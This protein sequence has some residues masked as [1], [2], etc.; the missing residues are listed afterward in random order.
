MA[1]QLVLVFH[2]Q[3]VG[4]TWYL[5]KDRSIACFTSHW[6]IFAVV[7]GIG[8]IVWV[9]GVPLGFW[10]LLYRARERHVLQRLKLLRRPMYATLRMKWLKEMR[11]GI[12]RPIQDGLY[13][14]HSKFLEIQDYHLGQYMRQKNLQVRPWPHIDRSYIY[15][16]IDT[17]RTHVII[18]SRMPSSI[19]CVCVCPWI[20][21]I[22]KYI[23]RCDW[24]RIRW[25]SH[26]LASFITTVMPYIS[27]YHSMYLSICMYVCMCRS[28]NRSL[29]LS[30]HLSIDPSMYLS[31]YLYIYIYKCVCVSEC[32]VMDFPIYDWVSFPCRVKLDRYATSRHIVRHTHIYIYIYMYMFFLT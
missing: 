19:V 5:V 29:Y 25:W 9:L 21:L 12:H 24:C 20:D 18:V 3:Q 6:Y 16:S 27:I 32:L 11:R 10:L 28:I 22:W 4:S 1:Q 17:V 8:F 30:I 15:L 7:A 23:S 31:I 2:C 14:I 13:S 26:A